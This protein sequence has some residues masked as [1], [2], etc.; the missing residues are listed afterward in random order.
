MFCKVMYFDG[1]G[2]DPLTI[3]PVPLAH[4][5]SS[6]DGKGNSWA[7]ELRFSKY[8]NHMTT[9]IR[10]Y[11]RHERLDIYFIVISYGLTPA[12]LMWCMLFDT[13]SVYF[14]LSRP[15][16]IWNTQTLRPLPNELCPRL[17]ALSCATGARVV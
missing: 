9:N 8:E 3:L 5:S 17:E 4:I 16:S 10:N 2:P 13:S 11:M 12:P 1:L 7:P 15:S 6:S 14:M